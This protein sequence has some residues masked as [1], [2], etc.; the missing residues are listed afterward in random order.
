MKLP[1]DH[2]GERFAQ[3]MENLATRSHARSAHIY[4]CLRVIRPSITSRF[5]TMIPCVSGHW[6]RF[7]ET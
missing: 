3:A 6:L 4:V 1:R 5:R 7:C 2:S